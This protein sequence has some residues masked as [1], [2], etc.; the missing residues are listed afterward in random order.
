MKKKEIIQKSNDFSKIINKNTK[1]KNKYFS[2][3]YEKNNDTL[4]GI[5]IPKK[6]GNA[7]IRNK[8]KRQ[9]KNIIDKN[10]IHIQKNYNYVI[11]VKKEIIELSY[12]KIEEELITLFKKIG[13]KYEKEKN[14]SFNN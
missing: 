7:V 8:I 1:V 14:T 12:L 3:F 5:S 2:I 10:K 9:V 4:F 13:E 6:T 11:I